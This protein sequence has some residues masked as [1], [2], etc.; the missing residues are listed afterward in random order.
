MDIY[1]LARE[2]MAASGN[3]DQWGPTHWPPEELIREDIRQGKSFACESGG[4]IVG[5][6]YFDQGEDI[7]PTYRI[8][9]GGEWLSAATA[10][11]NGGVHYGVVHRIASDGSVRGV[12]SFCL[13]WA[14]AQSGHLRVDTHPDNLPMQRLLEKCGFVRC[15]I[16]HVVEDNYPR[17]AYEK[18]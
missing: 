3:P 16:I 1:G 4:R 14:Y 9:E 8:I 11:P 6:F 17:Y 5:V 18:M 13:E 2:F 10:K 12:G 7:E 15:G